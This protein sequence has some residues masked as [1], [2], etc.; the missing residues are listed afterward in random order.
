LAALLQIAGALVFAVGIPLAAL[1]N[2]A[3]CGSTGRLR[4]LISRG[5][6]L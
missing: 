1:P 3:S 2:P 4:E 5:L 6:S